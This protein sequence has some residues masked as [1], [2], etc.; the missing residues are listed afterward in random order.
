MIKIKI[1]KNWNTCFLSDKKYNEKT[2]VCDGCGTVLPDEY[3]YII[4]KLKQAGLL[5]KRFKPLC[6]ICK[7]TARD[8]RYLYILRHS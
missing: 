4:N 7:K 5:W 3:S 8:K 1:T 6:C 2:I